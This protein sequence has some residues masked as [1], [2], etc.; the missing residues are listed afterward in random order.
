MSAAGQRPS[1]R[2]ETSQSRWACS[3]SRAYG[4]TPKRPVRVGPL[5]LG[6]AKLPVPEADR[7]LLA[8]YHA[9]PGSASAQALALLASAIAETREPV[10]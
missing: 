4:A 8:V 2:S 5:E 10:R 7:Q 3:G 9:A 1:S 6:W